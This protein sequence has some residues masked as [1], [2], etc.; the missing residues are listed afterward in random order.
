MLAYLAPRT[1]PAR[2]AASS[3]FSQRTRPAQSR[4]LRR[5]SAHYPSSEANIK[6]AVR[7]CQQHDAN[8]RGALV[9]SALL[10]TVEHAYHAR[11]GPL[12]YGT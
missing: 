1:A 10:Q 12:A 5:K 4:I 3:C 2:P 6:P 8:S 7:Y 9:Q 11:T